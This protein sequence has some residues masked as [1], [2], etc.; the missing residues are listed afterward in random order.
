MPQKLQLHI[1]DPCHENWDNMTPSEQGRFCDA[2]RKQVIDFSEMSDRE[3]VQFFKKP[4][5]GSVCG[6][7][8]N[9]QLERD[10]MIE[11]KRLPWIRYFFQFALPAF[12]MG[13]EVQAQYGSC[14]KPST[15]Q[16]R[17][18]SVKQGM[19]QYPV[20]LKTKLWLQVKDVATGEPVAYA[21]VMVRDD[22][23]KKVAGKDGIVTVNI[24]SKIKNAVITIS[25]IGYKTKTITQELS[26]YT[27][28]RLLGVE[29]EIDPV[30]MEEVVV[31]NTIPGNA[32]N[33]SPRP[34]MGSVSRN[35]DKLFSRSRG[36]SCCSQYSEAGSNTFQTFCYA[37][38]AWYVYLFCAWHHYP[39][40]SH[41]RKTSKEY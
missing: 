35:L 22:E 12:L 28:G 32:R 9:D 38:N 4:S 29:L 36:G 34:V 23:T 39:W 6:R 10:M 11:K 19:I 31:M 37:S 17:P 30:K 27:T 5:T 7:F 21:S 14:R 26:T 24:N 2:C 41:C 16:T 33:N 18:V 15:A 1:A 40:R 3:I 25:S 13:K 20:M 8:M